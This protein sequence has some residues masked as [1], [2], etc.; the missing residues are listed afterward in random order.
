MAA[1]PKSLTIRSYHVGFGDC[2]LL[3][4]AYRSPTERHVLIDFGS[5]GVPKGTSQSKRMM[6]IANDIKERT[7]GKLDAVVATHRHKDHISG[8]ATKNGRGPGDIIRSLE[9]KVVVQPW[10]EDPDLA[11]NATEPK[12]RRFGK[13]TPQHIAALAS[14]HQ[15]AAFAEQV[16]KHAR[17]F[18]K[19]LRA[20]LGFLGE[21]NIANLSAVKNLMTMAKRNAYVFAG[22]KSGLES[23]L[24][25]VKISVLGPPTVK[26]HEAIRKQR[27]KDPDEFWD[28]QARSMRFVAEDVERKSGG[29][30]LF[31]RHVRSRGRPSFPIDARWLVHHARQ[32]QGEQLLQIVRMLD[33]AMN[34]TSVILLFQVGSKRLL[35]P[36]DAQLENWEFSLAN[37]KIKRALSHVSLYKVGHH[38]SLNATPKSLWELFKNRSRDP[39]DPKRLRALMSTMPGKHGHLESGTEVPRRPLV[40]ALDRESDLFSTEQLKGDR[41]FADSLIEFR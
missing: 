23:I 13:A 31:P 2:F 32:L 21:N 11:T 9:P 20:Q 15:V 41:F 22:S 39:K 29:A 38:G 17:Y 5:T 37:A 19:D 18:D 7:G 35:F 27:A 4:I 12:L 34:N 36:G 8:F 25:G 30:V 3:S 33:D 26:Q 1:S 16:A 24:P 14:M 28:L 10:T 40:A 6:A